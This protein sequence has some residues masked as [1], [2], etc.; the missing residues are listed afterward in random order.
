MK[1]VPLTRGLIALVDDED[2]EVVSALR[3]HA[4]TSGKADEYYAASRQRGGGPGRPVLLMHRVIMQPASKEIQ[5]D[6]INGKRLDNRRSNLR[7]ATFQQNR[8]NI[9]STWGKSGFKGV[10]P[11]RR[12]FKAVVAGA[13]VGRASTAEG[14]A[15]IYDEYAIAK[16]GEFAATNKELGLLS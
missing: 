6:H 14:A 10:Y 2:F 15:R 12:R 11:S 5:V 7:F 13:V 8:A 9:R 4:L 3:W 16:W 1:E